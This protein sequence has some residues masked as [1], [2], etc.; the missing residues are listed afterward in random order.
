MA[1]LCRGESWSDVVCMVVQCAR[2]RSIVWSVRSVR[3]GL[4]A[5]H[6]E[7]AVALG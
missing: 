7:S 3:V 5:L 2:R 1:G 4:D 6:V